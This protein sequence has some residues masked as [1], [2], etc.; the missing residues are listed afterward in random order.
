MIVYVSAGRRVCR[1]RQLSVRA[2]A[3]DL[4]NT[5]C[6]RRLCLVLVARHRT[7]SVE[8][9]RSGST[10]DGVVT[11]GTAAVTSR[12]RLD[13][14]LV[15]PPF[16]DVDADCINSSPGLAVVPQAAGSLLPAAAVL[17]RLKHFLRIGVRPPSIVQYFMKPLDL[18]L[19][20]FLRSAGLAA[21]GGG[22]DMTGKSALMVNLWAALDLVLTDWRCP[23]DWPSVRGMSDIAAPARPR[24]AGR[25]PS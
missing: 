12:V 5:A 4:G 10:A 23:F 1:G 7:S 2:V 9:A 6:R 18:L 25:V 16:D 20:G 15:L 8:I 24:A 3:R 11:V 17:D 14:V 19:P 13:W 21:R 22:R